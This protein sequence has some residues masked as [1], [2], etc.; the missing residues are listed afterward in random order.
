MNDLKTVSALVKQIL[1]DDVDARNSD[2]VLYL[3]VLRYYASKKG[4][5]LCQLS[6]PDFLMNMEQKGLLEDG[7]DFVKL[8]DRGI[9][10]SNYVMSE[11]LL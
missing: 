6:V 3:E 9:D 8:T 5:D 11:F 1:E 7:E 2:N 4:I 10:V